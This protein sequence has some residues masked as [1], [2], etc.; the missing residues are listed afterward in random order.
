LQLINTIIAPAKSSKQVTAIA[1]KA[2]KDKEDK[3]IKAFNAY[4][5]DN[6]NNLN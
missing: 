5:I 2:P 6:Y 1:S 4:L 3:E